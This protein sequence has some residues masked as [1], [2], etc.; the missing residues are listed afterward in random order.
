[1]RVRKERGAVLVMAVL[2]MTVVLTFTAF[3][4]DIGTKRVA[5]R[6]MQ[7]LADATALDLA[8]QLKGRSA[9]T[10]L[11]DPK[12]NQV[13]KLAVLNNKT[14]IGSEPALTLA[15]GTVNNTTGAF[16][17]VSGGA[18]P[19]AVKVI[20]AT[21]VGFAF[22][23]GNG[24]T[25]RSAV[26]SSADP[27][28]CF[29][30]APT[31]LTLNTSTGALGPLLDHILKVNLHVLSPAGLLD[32]RGIEVPLADIAIELGAVTPQALLNKTSVSLYDFM[33]ASA[34][35]LSKNGYTAQASVLRAIGLQISGVTVNVA[36]ILNVDVANA[37]GLAAG[38]NVFDLV[39][40]AIFAANGTNS[41]SV[42]GLSASIPGVGGVDDLSVQI[43]EPPQIACG[44]AGVTAKSAQVK[45]HLKTS[46]AAGIS[47]VTDAMLDL[48][49]DLGR[50]EGTLSSISC[51]APSKAVI[52][53][54]TGL[55]SVYGPSTPDHL[56]L[57]S[58][59]L[60][61]WDDLPLLGPVT[62]AALK[63]LLGNKL[64][65]VKAQIGATAGQGGPTDL[66]FAASSSGT[67]IPSQSVSATSNVLNL[68]VKDTTVSLLSGSLLGDLLGALLAPL[69][70]AIVSG[71]VL[72]LVNGPVNTLLSTLLYPVF[73]LL[74][75]KIAQ[76]DVRV[77]GKID[78]QTVQ[79]VG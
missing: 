76:T 52:R 50:G 25:A 20:A 54:K 68:Q 9:D 56:A 28:L 67:S 30:V 26:A 24:T 2:L 57:L 4:V 14:K 69:L 55:A 45:V 74:G 32:V 31:A 65:A 23:A 62:V 36:K 51:A 27:T 10:V 35:A 66:T 60:A 13:K 43:T 46:V 63:L 5:R 40:A 78:C 38:I 6:D 75:V 42:K 18:I 77:H 19:D 39:T 72:P 34:T 59:N 49:A 41:L 79:L 44:K 21:T 47:G 71:I 7:S 15:L 29:S 53:A 12:F 48:N 73:S 58:L 8:R 61:N 70:N 22:V 64:L 3:A 37:A 1:M 33:L 17:P 11:A 16:T